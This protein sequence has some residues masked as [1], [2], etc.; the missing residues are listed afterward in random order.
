MRSVTQPLILAACLG[1]VFFLAAC[2]AA[3][4]AQAEPGS[5]TLI[6]PSPP[7]MPTAMPLP[8]TAALPEAPQPRSPAAQSSP[9]LQHTFDAPI[10]T[11]EWVVVDTAEV[12]QHPSIWQVDDG[13]L[14]QVSD[15]DGF[16]GMYPTALITG[17]TGWADYQVSVAAYVRGN[18]QVGVVARASDAGYYVFRLLPAAQGRPGSFLARYDAA[19]GL[20]ETI[21]STEGGFELDRWY[22][23]S[24]RLQG[25]R[26]EAFVDGRSVLV[27]HDASLSHGRAGVYGFAQGG[28]AF[29]NLSVDALP[30]SKP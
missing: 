24:L 12:L 25:D 30:A 18:D 11:A 23:L 2:N 8:P 5:D 16:P 27:A 1:L 10:D 13:R 14:Q 17:D 19:T 3:P 15:G 6:V 21:A 20:F 26:L 9:L 7:P 22:S 4:Q 28:L 29:D